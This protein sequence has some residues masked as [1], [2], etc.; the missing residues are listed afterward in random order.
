MADRSQYI[1][2]VNPTDVLFGRGS[3]PND[4][5][6]NIRFRNV[7]ANR[8]AEYMSTNHRQ[9]KATI[10]KDVVNT[11]YQSQGRFLKKMEARDLQ[12]LGLPPS[13]EAYQIVDDQTVMEKAKQALR[14][15]REKDADR[16]RSISPK[17]KQAASAAPFLNKL[18]IAFPNYAEEAYEGLEPWPIPEMSNQR[19]A[20]HAKPQQ[21]PGFAKY[22]QQLDG[23]ASG[24]GIGNVI[25]DMMRRGHHRRG[26]TNS[27]RDSIQNDQTA[28]QDGDGLSAMMESFRGMS[29]AETAEEYASEDSIGTIENT[30]GEQ[31][32]SFSMSNMSTGNMSISSVFTVNDK[33]DKGSRRNARMSGAS[34][35]SLRETANWIFDEQSPGSS[36]FLWPLEESSNA[37]AMLPPPNRPTSADN[38]QISAALMA[39]PMQDSQA[40]VMMSIGDLGV[41]IS[42]GSM[43]MTSMDTLAP[44]EEKK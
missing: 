12:K 19:V 11:V 26:S 21:N 1:T 4:H 5:E 43:M 31:H 14:Q 9:T 13:T 42:T 36:G 41:G 10:A 28:S 18:E 32:H 39:E 7:V 22:T 17:P 29:T 23:L 16:K 6:G 2:A 20:E 24:Q 25:A 40:G 27:R 34:L 15:N 8:K 30:F 33:S 35:E 3:G 38:N 37:G 44:H